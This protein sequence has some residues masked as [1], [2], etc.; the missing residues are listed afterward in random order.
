[1]F[2]PRTRLSTLIT[3]ITVMASCLVVPRPAIAVTAVPVAAAPPVN[4]RPDLVSAVLTARA[5]GTRVEVSGER[6]ESSTT[7]A[8]PDGT[9]TTESFSGPVRTRKNGAWT[10]I[11]TRLTDTGESVT[12]TAAIAELNL[13]DGGTEPFAKVARGARGLAMSWQ[14][15]L[16]A[17]KLKGDTA[18]YA[19]AVS[20]GDLEVK[21][22]PTGFSER[23][24][25]RERPSGPL[26][27]RLSLGLSDLR[28]S[29]EPD[30]RLRLTDAKGKLVAHAP[31]PHMWDSSTDPAS[32]L[33]AADA[34][35]DSSVE[36]TAAGPVLVLKP[37]QAF[38]NRADLTYPVII[39]PTATLVVTTDTW[40]ET[41]NYLDSQRGSAEL[42]VGTYDAG[43]HRAKAFMRFDVAKFTGKHIVD[44]D[45]ALYSYW[46]STCATNGS[47]ILVRRITSA[48]DSAA[49]TWD[50]QPSVTGDGGVTD[51]SAHGYNSSC[52]AAYAHWDI[53]AIVAAWASGSPNYGV[54]LRAG[55][56]YDT[57]TWR[58]Y[59]SA[60]YVDGDT[61]QEPHLTVTYNSYPATPTGLALTPSRTHSYSG[62]RF[63]SS[64]QPVL[65]AKLGDADPQNLKAQFEITADP[66][67]ADT[68]YGY[69]ATS[70]AVSS[71][72]TAKLAVPAANALPNGKHLRV[73]V[74][75]Y[76][77]VDYSKTWSGYVTFATN[78]GLPSAP[79][80]SCG[81]Y[82]K[83]AWTAK[84]DGAQPCVLDTASTDVQGYY[85][86][87]D[88]P[89]PGSYVED[90]ADGN[91][92]DPLQVKITPT[93]GWHTLYAR[94][95]DVAGNLS[96]T[97]T[98]YSFGVGV[99][100]V[101]SPAD[102][103]RT[104][105]AT[106]L[107]ARAPAAKNE[108]AYS[109]HRGTDP[110]AAWTP[111]P[112]ADVTQPGTATPLASWPQIRTDTAADFASL[113]WDVDKTIKGDGPVQLRACFT[114]AG[115]SQECSAPA[116]ITVERTAFG[117]S[118]ATQD[119][120][121]GEVSLLTGDFSIAA[122]DAELGVSRTHTTLS[123]AAASTSSEGVFGPGWTAALPGDDGAAY[124][125][126]DHS[127]DGYV[128]LFDSDGATL[129]YRAQSGGRFTG[130]SDAA[131]GSVIT[132]DSD[133][134]FTLTETGGGT[135]VFT[136][137]DAGWGVTTTDKAGKEGTTAYTR[138][139]AGRVTR[140]L[141]PVAAG[142][143]CESGLVPGC[144]ALDLAYAAT[145]TATGTAESG[146]GD[147]AGRLA[148]T[149]YTA[150][151]PATS[152]MRTVTVARYVYD[153]TGHL[154]ATWDA[155]I[156]PALKTT[157]SYDAKDR[158]VTVTPPGLA[159]WT[160]SY[161]ARGRLASV[162]R[163]DPAGGAA[164]RAIAY[165]VP[166]T[167]A[168]A[169]IDLSLTQTTTWAQSSDLP[170]V[171]AA[172]F[173][174]SHVPVRGSDGAYTPAVA[175]WPYGELTYLDV[176]GRAVNAAAWGAGAWQISA[177]RY[178]THGNVVWDLSAGNR[179]EALTPAD[180][181][182]PYTAGQADSSARALLLSTVN[183]Y[184]DNSMGLTSTSPA[185][186]VQLASGEVVSAR[187]VT[188]NTYDEGKP[189]GADFHLLTTTKTAPVVLDGPAAAAADATTTKL[190]YAPLGAGDT[191]GWTL[192]SPTTQATGKVTTTT[193]YDSAGR[194][195][196]TG[197]PGTDAGAAVIVHYTAAA[198]GAYA[199]CGG[200]PYWAGQ[201]CR[202][203]PRKQPEGKPLPVKVTTYD[204]WGRPGTVAETAGGTVR[205]TENRYDDAGRL[206]TTSIAVTP[207]ADG[208]TPVAPTTIGYDQ[209]SGLETTRSAG[210]ATITTG[211]DALGRPA[212]YTDADGNLST[213]TYDAD[214]RLKTLA[215][216]KGATT[217]TYDGADEHRGLP[218]RIDA[219]MG[220]APSAFTAA[221]DAAGRLVRQTYPDGLVATRA[222]DNADNGVSLTYDK[223]GAR[224]LGFSTT[225]SAS[226]QVRQADSVASSQVYNY[227]EAGRL[228]GVQDTYDETC[229]TRSYA[230]TDAG[231]RVS[232]ATSA[233]GDEANA[234]TVTHS[235]DG[236]DRIT[237][238]GYAY[239]SLGRTLSL[240][241]ASVTY[242]ADDMVASVTK[243]GLTTAYTLDPQ[244]RVRTQGAGVNHYA[245]G[246]DSPAWTTAS[247]GGWT[248]YVTGFDGDLIAVQ[249]HDGTVA[250]Q[251]ANPHG[252]IVATV[253]DDPGAAA[254]S[255][256][257][258][259]TEF[260]LPRTLPTTRYGWL[261][262]YQRGT[263]PASGL[264]LM[265]V[266]LY[267]PATGRFL[268]PDPVPGGNA[269]AY[270]YP[271]DPVNKLD[272]TGMYHWVKGPW[273]KKISH[274]KL[275][276]IADVMWYGGSLVAA[277]WSR[278]IFPPGWV[279]GLLTG[280]SISG[281]FWARYIDRHNGK[282]G[283]QIFA[284]IKRGDHWWSIPY[285]SFS[286]RKLD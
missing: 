135:T 15:P 275:A 270:V 104:Q 19:N 70:G 157:Y 184:D 149:T 171:G 175:D 49:L 96:G 122:D 120:G 185:H 233:C 232:E 20:G 172:V 115:G 156:T 235:Y 64:L 187:V 107:S 113:V 167:G 188:T 152:A 98:A 278:G 91:G 57:L 134:R 219:G 204:L 173:P 105:A 116:T 106:T 31:A 80:I 276:K 9:F 34:K 132:K 177:T 86:S 93:D 148:K 280:M 47:G 109:Y 17:P 84:A 111:V 133:T 92:G 227:D 199:E 82:P 101:L 183:T 61:A 150:Y 63:V 181:T 283:G 23:V 32:G 83:D 264:I 39:D 128:L 281:P 170:R 40:M 1:M 114:T 60:N 8:N 11:D 28:V 189:D 191:S 125:F 260:G 46:S 136:K 62:G 81:T 51:K 211:Y 95:I 94:A 206:V 78:T 26:T 231:N 145:T 212:K 100:S 209:A 254:P 25:L 127:A 162:S 182:D 36:N 272:L 22:L 41:P 224:W 65:S 266:R 33:A 14:S 12:P 110:S 176:N 50:S 45:L 190:G 196:E 215:D 285:P 228:S 194:I 178:D 238:T 179:A 87:L 42:R 112:P 142:V 90:T 139:S 277:L 256:Y 71:G 10:P 246:G 208:G 210:G 58:R 207:A 265:G 248:R 267:N 73:R 123:P 168:G 137:A 108:V 147:Y 193:R 252:D 88:N 286:V 205:K 43:D 241:G 118:Y 5:Q 79:S 13:S 7:Y 273:K 217:Y 166:I 201:V 245:G 141:A 56:E 169:P 223:S 68:T 44:T 226:G 67:Y 66:A 29:Q 72:G 53:D 77:G 140:M 255:T 75:G 48:W 27:L 55:D 154:R 216:G 35:V 138:D 146:W 130:I 121:P 218:T 198:N 214:G 155:R 225:V 202:T 2:P 164:T 124:S 192:R 222:Y 249:S 74:R 99:G 54:Q 257:T 52:P 21:A 153:S 143:S 268:S 38:L 234:A 195:V 159:T 89:T 258:E 97:T 197:K 126:E 203:A 30:G 263:D 16:P 24:V 247:G 284:G 221:Y 230:F 165:D 18:V 163:P 85:W 237:D 119:L 158:V 59:R 160:M 279:V 174:A 117:S 37:D 269:N 213:R 76:D 259:Q 186:P 131:D 229:T 244:D 69:T 251:L 180:G 161:D 243:D 262:G 271:A 240:P 261:G 239:D 144:R 103:D 3:I 220:T 6:T 250:L 4:E 200:K 282:H 102:G 274:S 129:T 253:A 242:H 151:D 236:A